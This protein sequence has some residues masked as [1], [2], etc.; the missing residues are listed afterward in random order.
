MKETKNYDKWIG[1]LSISLI[2][3][4][5][6]VFVAVVSDT[7]LAKGTYGVEYACYCHVSAS[8]E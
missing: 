7:H 5:A 6:V 1:I 2:A 4:V 3:I 8:L